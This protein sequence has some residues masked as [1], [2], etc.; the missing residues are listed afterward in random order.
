MPVNGNNK[1]FKVRTVQIYNLE[2]QNPC[3]Y[4]LEDVLNNFSKDEELQGYMLHSVVP[5]DVIKDSLGLNVVR[6]YVIFVKED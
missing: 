2:N 1:P 6:F 5:L 3:V 4:E